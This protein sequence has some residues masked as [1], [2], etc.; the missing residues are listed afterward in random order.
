M[1]KVKRAAWSKNPSSKKSPRGAEKVTPIENQPIV[2]RVGVLDKD[3]PWSWE[4][5]SLAESWVEMH[6]KM[7][8]LE[9][10]TF[11]GVMKAGSHPIPCSRLIPDA[12]K[13]L[14]EINQN[15]LDELFSLRLSGKQ[16]IW[17]IRDRNVFKILWWDPNHEVCPSQKKHT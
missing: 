12:Q 8:D 11:G 5:T 15:D 16:R 17:G 4:S 1:A 13:R 9:S 14:R 3:G 6:S 2:W 7:K 10:M